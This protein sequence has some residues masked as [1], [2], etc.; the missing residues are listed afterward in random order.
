MPPIA[1][2]IAIELKSSFLGII[3]NPPF[4]DLDFSIIEGNFSASYLEK[5]KEPKL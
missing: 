1:I 4:Y 5:E 2:P 3:R